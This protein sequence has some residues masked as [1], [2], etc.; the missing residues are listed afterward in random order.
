[1]NKIKFME[2]IKKEL[3]GI[4]ES[5]LTEILYDYE[6]HF[7]VG[8]SEGRSEE[9]IAKSLGNPYVLAKEMKTTYLKNRS[10]DSFSITNFLQLLFAAFSVIFLN[11]VIVLGPFIG[12]VA[13]LIAIFASGIAIIGSGLFIIFAICFPNLFNYVPH[14]LPGSFISL[15][16]M[17]FGGLWTIGA[18]YLI[19]Y[20]YLITIKYV[21]FN[22]NII[23]NR[24]GKND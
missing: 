4:P 19:K 24:R 15:A 5:D 12:I 10:E 16:L 14:P 13:A 7:N 23:K 1:M 21:N 17:S 9:E 18:Y 11:L 2:I 22:L 3:S 8:I 6:E 20:F